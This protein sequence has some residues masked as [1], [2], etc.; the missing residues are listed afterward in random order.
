MK[1]LKLFNESLSFDEID[2]N[3]RDICLELSDVGFKIFICYRRKEEIQ[4]AISKP[5]PKNFI[6][7]S[8]I[9]EI[10]LRVLDYMQIIGWDIVVDKNKINNYNNPSVTR[11]IIIKDDNI[12]YLSKY[13]DPK[14]IINE[15]MNAI[16][17]VFKERKK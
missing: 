15:L 7:T 11:Y 12:F 4:I 1:H 5:I 2:R 14:N 16:M 13:N 17:L 9:H 8:E 3:L 10:I 6:Y